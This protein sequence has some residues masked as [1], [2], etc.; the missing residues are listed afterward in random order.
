[1]NSTLYKLGWFF[2]C[3]G[4]ASYDVWV[5]AYWAVPFMVLCALYWLMQLYLDDPQR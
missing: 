2:F 3:A 4:F 5:E 1:M